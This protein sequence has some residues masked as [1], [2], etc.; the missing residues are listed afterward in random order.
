[1]TDIAASADLSIDNL[2][3]GVIDWISIES[4]SLDTDAVNRMVD[5]VE[6]EFEV[7]GLETE[8]TPGE[9]GW[10]DLIRGR[11]PGSA[12]ANKGI[13]VV[14]HIDTVHPSAPRKAVTLSAS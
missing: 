4:P 12:R 5:H 6:S 7:V 8:R 1:M 13:L 14:S 10:G 2:V 11:A 3:Q 9:D